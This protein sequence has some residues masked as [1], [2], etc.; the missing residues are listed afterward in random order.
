MSKRSSEELFEKPLKI[1]CFGV[2]NRISPTA[3]P[4]SPPFEQIRETI[5]ETSSS[6]SSVH[7]ALESDQNFP[8]SENESTYFQSIDDALEKFFL[9]IQKEERFLA[10][11]VYTLS[12]TLICATGISVARG[13]IPSIRITANNFFCDNYR[14][15]IS[16]IPCDWTEFLS[17][18]KN[19]V[20]PY[21]NDSAEDC[22]SISLNEYRL[23][24][25][26]FLDEKALKLEYR[27]SVLYLSRYVIYKLI[28]F[29]KLIDAHLKYLE[30]TSF[31]SRYYQLLNVV[32]ECVGYSEHQDSERS[33]TV[34]DFIRRLSL[35]YEPFIVYCLN[36]LLLFHKERILKDFQSMKY[37]CE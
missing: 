11:M 27:S 3:A 15:N 25:C 1:T 14:G 16:F 20:K 31:C 24:P 10:E 34:L 18:L 37:I 33:K 8:S 23:S 17:Y 22:G 6:G 9:D 36:E 13:F 12:P 28:E 26:K 2:K 30:S 21:L 4:S 29:E 35:C 7:S 32:Y 5:M 19:T